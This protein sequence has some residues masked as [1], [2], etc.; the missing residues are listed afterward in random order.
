MLSLAVWVEKG[1]TPGFRFGKSIV[2]HVPSIPLSHR[3]G[4]VH[5]STFT[6]LL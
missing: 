2:S 5:F 6:G 4:T 1:L 3:R